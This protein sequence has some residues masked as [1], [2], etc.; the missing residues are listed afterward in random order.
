MDGSVDIDRWPVDYVSTHVNL[1]FTGLDC[2][3]HSVM[4]QLEYRSEL[5]RWLKALQKELNFSTLALHLA[6]HLMDFFMDNHMIPIEKLSRVALVC[7]LT[8]GK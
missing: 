1:F 7:V 8:A 6:V 2:H 3:L 5:V 4:L